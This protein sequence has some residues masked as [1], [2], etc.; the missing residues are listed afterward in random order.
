MLEAIAYGRKQ[1]TCFTP[2]NKFIWPNRTGCRCEVRRQEIRQDVCL[3][4]I[5]CKWEVHRQE[6]LQDICL[7]LIGPAEKNVTLWVCLYKPL[8]NI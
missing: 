2:L 1:A 3:P 8:Q 7:P 5:G 6:V 4:L